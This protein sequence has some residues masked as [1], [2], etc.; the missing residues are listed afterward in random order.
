MTA[1]HRDTLNRRRLLAAGAG[2]AVVALVRPALAT[3]QG[4]ADAI[5]AFAEG[6][7]RAQPGRVRLE[8]PAL[9]E[10]G[11]SAPLTVTV[12]SPMT[13]DAFVRRIA[14]FNEKN[15]QPNVATFHLGPRS[16][17][18][19]VSTRMRLADSQTIVAIAELSDGTFWSDSAEVIVTLAA[20][21]EG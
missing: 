11:N 2:A 16:G 20:C 4:M 19:F 9:V 10:N 1:P 8:L 15:P 5:R 12:D 3:P 21:L 14:V 6:A 7:A 17:R 18:A 13:P